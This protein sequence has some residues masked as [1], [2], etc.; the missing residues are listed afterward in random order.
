MKVSLQVVGIFYSQTDIEVTAANPTVQD[1]MDAAEDPANYPA[2]VSSFKYTPHSVGRDEHGNMNPATMFSLSATYKTG[3]T[4]RVEENHYPAG[5]YEMSESFALPNTKNPYT[6][7]QY[8]L[9][10]KDHKRIPTAAVSEPFS[11]QPLDQG[12][13]QVAKVV[14][15]L[16]SILSQPSIPAE[17]AGA[18]LVLTRQHPKMS[19]RS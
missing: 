17:Q 5:T 1:L 6:V 9:L 12:E 2:N 11:T 14:W 10:D 8:Y 19:G 13:V 3:F 18:D 4:S 7:W 15:R 16:V